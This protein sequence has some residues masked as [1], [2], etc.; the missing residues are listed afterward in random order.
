VNK[1]ESYGYSREEK[2]KFEA[3]LNIPVKRKIAKRGRRQQKKKGNYAG[4][5]YY[6]QSKVY[7]IGKL[8]NHA[9]IL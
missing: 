9:R 1:R 8:S 6:R 4:I 7:R 2:M 5:G 3:I